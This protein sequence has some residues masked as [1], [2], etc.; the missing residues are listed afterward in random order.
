MSFTRR[1]FLQA[2]S[3][4]ALGL[5]LNFLS[6]EITK[7]K[8]FAGAMNEEDTKL[9][10]I[11]QRGGNDGVNTV[12]PYGDPEYNRANRPTL[13][14]PQG[15]AINLGN[16]FARLHP[17][18][19]PM[20]EIYNHPNLTGVNGPGNL[21]I[22]HRVGYAGQSKSHFNSQQYWENGTPG[23]L[24]FE[25]GMIYRLV[26]LTMNPLENNLAA[27][28]MSNSQMTALRGELPIPTIRDP[29]MFNFSGDSAKSGKLIGRLPSIPQG[30]DGQG[31]L[32][33]YGGPRDFADK[34]YRDLVYN[35][36]LAL[37]NAM[38]IVQDAVA[39]GPYEPSG[40]AVY[41]NGNFGNRLSQIAMLL[42]RTPAQVLGVN[43][44]GWDTHTNQGQINGRQGNLLA[45]VAQGFR[46]L[47][48]DLQ[49]QWDK[50][51]IITMT[52]FGRTSKENGSKGTDHGHACVMFAAGGRVQ[53]G[54][55]NC[56]E[57]TWQA[58]DMLSASDRYVK[59]RT[60][61]RAI[62][63]EIFKRHFGNSEE[64]I[65]QIIPDYSQA[66]LDNPGDFEFLNFLPAV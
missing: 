3:L 11:F 17:R 23:D 57:S 24:A 34:P 48:R 10:F 26:A 45:Q 42:K 64:L 20:M 5:G 13:Y 16:N 30:T 39:Q 52:E 46:A 53:G 55:Y 1:E 4:T 63:A 47:Y 59:R 50:L 22:I 37:T 31:L 27:A 56:D 66:A 38:N 49:E 54:V 62:F 14:I 40:G 51:I 36:G 58:G 65:E 2:G 32:G 28:T 61:Y 33:A 6:P 9:V 60:D 44:G 35:T 18:M 7:D 41:P 43:I 21:A 15:N 8:V 29:Q 19:L 25:E 12:I